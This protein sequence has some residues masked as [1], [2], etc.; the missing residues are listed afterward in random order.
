MTGRADYEAWREAQE[1]PAEI[2]L[3]SQLTDEAAIAYR[4]W[5]AHVA[6]SP[7]AFGLALGMDPFEA[8]DASN[9]CLHGK[10]PAEGCECFAGVKANGTPP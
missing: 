1:P 6:E 10:V 9:E 3:P 7:S 2:T 4:K 8:W 5:F